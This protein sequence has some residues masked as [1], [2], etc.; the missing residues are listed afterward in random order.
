MEDKNI[1]LDFFDRKKIAVIRTLM[2]KKQNKFYL[3]EISE[4]AKVPIATTFRILNKLIKLN[5]VVQ[6]KISKFKLYQLNDS[7]EVSES[8][9]KLEGIIKEEKVTAEKFVADLKA[10][11]DVSLIIVHGES[12]E[13]KA[14]LLIIGNSI[15]SDKIKEVSVKAK[16]KYSFVL[17]PLILTK[18]LFEQM[19]ERNLLKG[20]LR[21]LYENKAPVV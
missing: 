18:D 6:T 4:Q 7:E 5:L 3:T 19:K 21:V 20:D 2:V 14:N 15:N 12:E 1:F 9:A 8:M 16:E 11:G 13:N 10:A 17:L